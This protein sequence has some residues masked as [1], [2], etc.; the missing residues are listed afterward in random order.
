MGEVYLAHDAK[1]NRK[2]AI[3]LL[4]RDS[5]AN[6]QA[7]RRLEREARAAANLDHPNICAI[8][9]VGDEDGRS[10]ICMQYVEG[11]TLESR[12]KRQPLNLSESLSISTQVV[13]ALAEA[14]A[15]GTIHRDIKPSNIMITTRGAVKVMDFGLAKVVQQ[16]E[17]FTSE[18]ETEALLS[19]PG[20]ILGTLPYM[21]PE[22]VRGEALDPRSDIFSFGVVLYEMLTGLQPFTNKSSA[23]TASAILTSEPSPLTRFCR[24]VPSE[25]ERIVNKALRKDADERYQTAKDL[26]IDLKNLRRELDIQSEIKRPPASGVSVSG[27]SASSGDVNNNAK[28]MSTSSTATSSAKPRTTSRITDI[29]GGHKPRKLTAL[30]VLLLGIAFFSVWYYAHLRNTESTV[31]SIAVMPLD[32]QNRDPDSEYLSDGLTESIITSLTQL[33]N[34]QVIL[35][36]SDFLYKSK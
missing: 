2:V 5:I 33:A 17:S 24:D 29:L 3:K 1:L 18:A 21:S 34:L 9:E 27:T 36:S 28:R 10:F 4:P 25:L 11:E 6:E 22:Q 15:H 13:D 14:H 30:V 35:L 31:E 23:V 26:M 8:Y 16:A 19:A 12:M 7:N 20:T 32:N